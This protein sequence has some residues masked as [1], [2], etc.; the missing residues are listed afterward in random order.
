MKADVNYLN[1]EDAAKILGVN[2]STIKRWTDS[3]RLPCIKTAGGH[4]KFL[5][6]HLAE[7]LES[8][9]KQKK[10]ARF[11][12]MQEKDEQ[13]I[14]LLILRGDFNALI[15][16]MF[17]RAIRYD[18]RTLTSL[19][20]GLF[21]AQYPLYEI[22]DNLVTPVLHRIGDQWENNKLTVVEEHFASQAIKDALVR[23][24]GVIALPEKEGEVV[25]LLNLPSELHDIGLK[26]A[27]HILE[28]RGFRVL[29]SGQNTPLFRVEQVLENFR[30]SR[31][32]VSSTFVFDRI[33]IQEEFDRLHGM[34]ETYNIKMYLGGPGFASLN[35]SMPMVVAQLHTFRE[36]F[37]K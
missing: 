37:E 13:Q 17:E 35:T 19:M 10:N 14:N 18:R 9:E 26:M 31:L 20:R 25:M 15:D 3:E 30:P 36:V 33:Q 4:R 34:C 12:S 2:I 6:E 32:Y 29:N 1:T 5:M 21:L 28:Y 23:L 22:Y 24:Q 7:F 16:F 27:D 11:F 8:N